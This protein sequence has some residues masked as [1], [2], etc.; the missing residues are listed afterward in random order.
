MPFE[1]GNKTIINNGSVV[2]KDIPIEIILEDNQGIN[3]VNSF[4]HNI[5]YW[6]NNQLY[7]YNLNSDLFEY[8]EYQCGKGSATFLLPQ[9]LKQGSNSIYI[10]G[11]DNANN[12]TLINYNLNIETNTE[13]YVNNLYNFPNPFS[14]ATFFTFYLSKYPTDIEIN[15]YN[16]QGEQIHTIFETCESYYNV[17]KWDGKTHFGKELSNGAYI[18]SFNS[19]YNGEVY[20]T[21]NKIAKLK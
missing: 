15:I 8:D 16:I 5:R 21:I 7:N 10:E 9:D 13:S 19:N 14:E 20:K 4:Q 2:N 1:K 17:I 6:F 18:Y 11:W 3:L 12:R